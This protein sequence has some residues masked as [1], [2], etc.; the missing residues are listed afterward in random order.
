MT[1]ASPPPRLVGRFV[2]LSLL[3]V[4]VSSFALSLGFGRIEA[5][6]ARG[7][8][9]DL[10]VRIC[11][12][13]FK[14]IE[15]RWLEKY[16]PTDAAFNPQARSDLDELF[17]LHMASLEIREWVWFNRQGRILYCTNNKVIG[18]NAAED[19]LIDKAVRGQTLARQLDAGKPLYHS[20]DVFDVPLLEVYV[21]AISGRDPRIGNTVL[22]LYMDATPIERR[23]AAASRNTLIICFLV[24][25][26]LF[27]AVLHLIRQAQ[28]RLHHQNHKLVEFSHTLERRVEERTNE[29][30]RTRRLADVGT[31]SAGLAHEIN[32]PLATIASC[33]EGLLDRL[34]ES[35]GEFGTQKD[36]F[37]DY[38]GSIRD[39]TY[40]C[41]EI[42][43]A[44]LDYARTAPIKAEEVDLGDLVREVALLMRPLVESARQTLEVEAPEG[45]LIVKAAPPQLKQ[46][47]VNLIRNAIDAA[48]GKRQRILIRLQNQHP[49][50]R[51][52]VHD[53]GCGL[54][55]EA[56][57][58]MFEPFYTTKAPGRGSG[59]GLSVSRHI[60]ELHSGELTAE[61]REEGGAVFH[62][63]LPAHSGSTL[64]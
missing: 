49:Y 20:G 60:V 27:V 8:A 54:Q 48:E 37:A 57:G 47:L 53:E 29:L 30:I 58:K 62:L 55:E 15:E 64:V 28:A 46:V 6:Q 16:E 38:L 43:G 23:A 35:N 31:L 2:V 52:S 25:L 61:N 5:K 18:H 4:A 12:H 17:R 13:V 63:D 34:V 24:G 36:D 56:N 42:T 14:E 19:G 33:A 7:I 21:P 1:T 40:R 32:N 39:E 9:K 45:P 51:I 10:A 59:M 11:Q 41:K 22:E 50:H 44:L 3:A 26:M